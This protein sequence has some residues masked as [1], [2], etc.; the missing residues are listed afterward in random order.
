MYPENLSKFIQQFSRLPGVGSKSSERLGFYILSQPE[1]FARSL[2]ESIIRLKTDSVFCSSCG[3]LSVTDPCGICTDA[4]RDNFIICVVEHP[5]DIYYI[6]TT[7][8]FHGLYHVLGG[9]LSP[10]NGV[11]PGDLKIEKLVQRVEELSV[12]EILFATSATTEGD[13]TA[14]YI[15]NLLQSTKIRFT[16]LARGIP[17][18]TNLQ[19]AGSGSLSQAIRSREEL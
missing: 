4:A 14:L 19:Y 8:S 2:A 5:A 7:N 10:L 9:V 3:N 1:E 17:V 6:E 13:T 16:H 18:G 15:K 12:T 11:S